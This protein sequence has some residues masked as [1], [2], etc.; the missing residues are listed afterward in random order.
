VTTLSQRLSAVRLVLLDVDGVLTDGRIVYTG[1][2]DEIKSFNVRDGY[3]IRLMLD[4]GIQVGIITGRRS[5][6][7]RHRCRDLGIDLVYAGARDKAPLLAE[8]M[9]KQTLPAS[10]I[11]FVGDDLP[12]LPVMNRVGC[13]VAV[14][15]AHEE[16]LRRAHMVTMATGGN[17]AVRELAEALLRAH[18]KWERLVA[19]LL[20]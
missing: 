6:A 20:E 10:A 9:E 15:D 2:G 12:D 4:A 3:G 1:D 16:L 8:I 19:S 13:A 14:A 11:A 7:L 18:G 17:G 5:G